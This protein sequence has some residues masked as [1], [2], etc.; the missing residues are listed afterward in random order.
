MQ[1]DSPLPQE[2]VPGTR[3]KIDCNNCHCTEAGI[4]ACTKKGCIS[5]LDKEMQSDEPQ[6]ELYNN[7]VCKPNE[8]KMEVS[9]VICD[10]KS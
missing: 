3:F 7:Q 4:V 9:S 8:I 5:F 1:N 10:S 2:C 6:T